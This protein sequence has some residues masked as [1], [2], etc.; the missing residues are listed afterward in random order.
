M[1][2]Y[3]LTEQSFGDWCVTECRI[4]EDGEKITQVIHV[5]A[6][7]SDAYDWLTQ[8]HDRTEVS[9]IFHDADGMGGDFF[10]APSDE[11]LEWARE[12]TQRNEE[13]K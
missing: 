3:S 8:K 7:W 5:A 10:P 6:T 11:A 4:G 12:F 9:G 1:I 2:T 13:A